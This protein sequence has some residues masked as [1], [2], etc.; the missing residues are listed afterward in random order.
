MDDKKVIAS[1]ETKSEAKKFTFSNEE[2]LVLKPRQLIIEQY[3]VIINDINLFVQQYIIAK[4][5]PR[6][7]ISMDTHD[8]TFNIRDNT[9]EAKLKPPEI[10]KPESGIV[11]PNGNT[12]PIIADP[13]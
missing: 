9:L 1:S 5:L 8:I 6:L 12:K 10:I 13:L 2:M 4:V 3:Q 11:L 7:G